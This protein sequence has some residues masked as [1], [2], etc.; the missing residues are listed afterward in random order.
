VT[1][2]AAYGSWRSPITAALVASQGLRLGFVAIDG[3][4]ISWIEGRPAEGGRNVLVRRAADG[5]TADVTPAPFNVRSRVHEYGGGAYVV[6]DGV[7]YFSNFSDQRIYRVEVGWSRTL[8]R[9][10]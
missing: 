7:A 4:D 8:R 9:R 5:T 10:R 1:P 3:D 2:S 6:S